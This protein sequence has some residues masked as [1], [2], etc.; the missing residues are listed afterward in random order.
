MV[1]ES[2]RDIYYGIFKLLINRKEFGLR[3]FNLIDLISSGKDQIKCSSCCLKQ[4][5]YV[6]NR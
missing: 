6:S 3:S 5:T 2:L 4:W 1:D